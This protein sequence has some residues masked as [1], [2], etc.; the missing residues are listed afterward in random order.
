MIRS[1]QAELEVEPKVCLHARIAQHSL[2]NHLHEAFAREH[3][4][5]ITVAD[6]EEEDVVSERGRPAKQQVGVCC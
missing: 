3:Q 6:L 1:L 2:Q 5:Q 4:L